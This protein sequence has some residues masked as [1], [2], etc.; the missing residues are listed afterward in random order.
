MKTQ[1]ANT[2]A[3]FLLKLLPSPRRM[4]VAG[5]LFTA[6]LTAPGQEARFF[7]IAGPTAAI[8]TA[9]QPGG[10][11]VWSNAQPGATY[12]VQTVSSLPGGKNWVDYVQLPV[13]QAVN[14]N[15]LV[16]FNPPSGMAFIPAGTFMM[17]NYLINGNSITNDPEITDE[18]PTNVTVSAFYMD[19]NLVGYHQWQSTYSYATNH[20]Y[21]FDYSGSGNAPNQPVQTVN[22]YD[23]VKWCNARSQQAGLTPVYFTDA[24]MT[25]V[26]TNEDTDAVFVNWG[27]EGYR[28][29]TEAEWEKAARGGLV[30]QRFP[31]GN[32]ISENLANYYG[33]T[34]GYGYDLGPNGLNAAFAT[35]GEP[36]TSPVGSFAPN[37]YGLYDMAGDV[38]EWCWDWYGVSYAGGIDPRG[39]ASTD[40]G[41][42]ARVLRGGYWANYADQLRCANRINHV[43]VSAYYSFGFRCMRGL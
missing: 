1:T 40:P 24:G 38:F 22:W 19:E 17:G 3:G 27:G 20:G 41:G 9:F 35:G 18:N 12:T 11:I 36:Y 2:T 37:G 29:P 4:A 16:D 32:F 15:K 34:N 14:T 10:S 8:I 25:R 33:N 21:G 42:S 7:R 5:F 13:G 31:R 30:G 43:P 26:Y 39:P 23:C 28:L 6:A